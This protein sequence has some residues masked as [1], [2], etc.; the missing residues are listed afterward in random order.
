[1][2]GKNNNHYRTSDFREAVFLRTRGVPYLTIEW[3]TPQRAFFVFEKPPEGTVESW[4]SGS[5]GGVRA[6]LEA[7]DFFR[8]IIK[9]RDR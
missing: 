9:G 6:T 7:A 4:A 8:D 5:D 1:M 3:P 2:E